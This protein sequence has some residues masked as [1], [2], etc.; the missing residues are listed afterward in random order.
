MD[1]ILLCMGEFG[2]NT[3]IL[4]A[5]LGSFLSYTSPAGEGDLLPAAPGQLDPRELVELYRFREINTRTRIFGVT[6][7]PLKFSGSPHFFNAVFG[8]ENTNAVYVP[9]PAASIKPLLQ[10]AEE[11]GVSGLSVTVPHKETVLPHLSYESDK[12][13]SIGACNTLVYKSGG[14]RGFNT[15]ALGF[16]DSLL[17]FTGKKNLRGM[18]ITIVGAGGAAR[19]VAFEVRR[20]KGKALIINRSPGRA[21]DLALR[22]GFAWAA[23]DG[24]G[25]EMM[26]KYADIIIQTT[27]AGLEPHTGEDP[28]VYYKFTGRELVMD[29]IYKPE[30]TRCLIRAKEAGC[31]ILNG[32]DMLIRQARYQYGYFMEKE[33]PASLVSRV[34]F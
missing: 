15:D 19:A 8:I 31:K 16:S 3:R 4:A 13:R 28:L 22:Y 23:L 29:L 32:Y 24:K 26:E 5:F 20:L 1:K 25:I 6:G 10:L 27:S 17:E 34:G 11:L 18:K 30:K 21:R 12:V 7:Y 14:W 33:F 9:F 2:V